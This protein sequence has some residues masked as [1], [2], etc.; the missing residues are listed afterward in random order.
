MEWR[1]W[2][3]EWLIF[4]E[5]IFYCPYKQ[6]KP[7]ESKTTHFF[8][9][10]FLFCD[11]TCSIT[12]K[13]LFSGGGPYNRARQRVSSANHS[14]RRYLVFLYSPCHIYCIKVRVFICSKSA[15]FHA[16][17]CN[18]C[19]GD[20]IIGPLRIKGLTAC[21]DCIKKPL[22]YFCF[23]KWASYRRTVLFTQWQPSLS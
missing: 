10:I 23:F 5:D 19:R 21:D 15:F 3:S 22:H 7:V 18:K 9:P 11:S 13:V 12:T 6:F 16:P 8:F 1:V 17:P 4:W 20:V 14:R 2:I